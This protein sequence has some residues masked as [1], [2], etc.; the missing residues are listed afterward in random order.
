MG[1][2]KGTTI[3]L[4][5]AFFICVGCGPRATVVKPA[6]ST[7]LSNQYDY[8]DI[9]YEKG[10]A[11]W[12]LMKY[13]GLETDDFLAQKKTLQLLP[14]EDSVCFDSLNNELKNGV[15]S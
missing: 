3:G 14:N 6:E 2:G 9:Y 13:M 5:V 8:I 7:P 11:P 4:F 10:V 1:M 12:A 15:I